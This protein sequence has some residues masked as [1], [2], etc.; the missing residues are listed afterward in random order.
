[1]KTKSLALASA[2]VCAGLSTA[3]GAQSIDECKKPLADEY[4]EVG[5]T[6]LRVLFWDVYDA[7]LYTT[8]GDFDWSQRKQQR[9]ALLLRYLRDI[10]AKE[11][12]ETTSE[13]W[14]KLGFNSQEQS[15]WLDKLSEMWPDIKEDDCIL[16]KETNEGYAAFYQ[17]DKS[18]GVINSSQFTE[19]FLAIWLSPESRFEEERDELVGKQ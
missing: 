15:Q 18:L 6:R 13:E 11:L 17:G 2:L 9:K 19:Q 5:Q 10:E 3:V 1:M 12:V 4:K 14:E 16:L 8:D 7:F